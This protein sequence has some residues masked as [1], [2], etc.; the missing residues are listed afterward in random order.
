MSDLESRKITDPKVKWFGNIALGVIVVIIVLYVLDA[1][2]DWI[3]CWKFNWGD[4]AT[5]ATGAIAA[6][7]AIW[8][9]MRQAAI[10]AR[11]TEI[12]NH[13]V[14]I[15]RISLR[16]ELYDRRLKIFTD[17]MTY[18]ANVWDNET[19]RNIEKARSFNLAM[20][21]SKFLFNDEI[22][23]LLNNM[24]RDIVQFN[25]VTTRLDRP[26]RTSHDQ[27]FDRQEKLSDAIREKTKR[28]EELATPYMRVDEF[29]HEYPGQPAAPSALRQ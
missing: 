10:S 12:L 1:Q 7:G 28:F 11:Q 17:V 6:V 14:S 16:A 29:S 8:I 5:L 2:L 13:Q 23:A 21:S 27:L 19:R 25:S 15:E 4:F 24:F 26:Y 3:D 20:E 18:A 9:G 22:H